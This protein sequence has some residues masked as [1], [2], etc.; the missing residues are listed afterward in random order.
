MTAATF[1]DLG[2]SLRDSHGQQRTHCPQCSGRS[3]TLSVNL[4][5]GLYQCF[6][7]GWSGRVGSASH[8]LD[9]Y[10]ERIRKADQARDRAREQATRNAFALWNAAAPAMWHPYLKGKAV[11]PLGIRQRDRRLVVPMFDIDGGLWSC[12]TID[13]DGTKLFLRGGRTTG[14]FYPIGGFE[15]F[16]GAESGGL[17]IF[18][19]EGFATGAA[20]HLYFRPHA[21]V[22][23]AFNC[24]NLA[25]VANALRSR[26]RHARLVIAADNDRWT[27]GNPGLTHARRAADGVGARVIYPQFDGLDVSGKPTDFCDL[28]LL[29]REM[30]R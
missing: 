27:V 1:D 14:L 18:I 4:D 23:V 5:R 15:G 25:H 17:E 3:K 8:W 20:L 26:Y 12:Q 29:Q 16:V 24:G 6:R 30:R 9:D 7:C 11:L 21:P 13:E 2:I 28:H 22:A 10:R 19:A